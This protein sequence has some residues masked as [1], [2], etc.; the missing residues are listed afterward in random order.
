MQNL[1]G[2]KY[3]AAWP[4]VLAL[5][6][7]LLSSIPPAASGIVAPLVRALDAL[8]G[9]QEVLSHRE[10]LDSA[11]RFAGACFRQIGAAGCHRR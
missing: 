1:L 5:V 6:R 4:S 2:Y 10:I 11:R 8:H 9:S 7:G 3:K